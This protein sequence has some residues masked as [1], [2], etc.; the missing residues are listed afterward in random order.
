M[1]SFICL[2]ECWC[3][4]CAAQ[5]EDTKMM[6]KSCGCAPLTV[7]DAYRYIFSP[8]C[9]IAGIRQAALLRLLPIYWS[10]IHCCPSLVLSFSLLLLPL[11]YPFV[12][13]SFA[14]LFW[15]SLISNIQLLLTQLNLFSGRLCQL[16][17]LSSTSDTDTLY[18]ILISWSAPL[19]NRA[20]LCL[21]LFVFL[22]ISKYS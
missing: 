16:G 12:R 11:D 8:W 21:L 2:E 10:S 20:L 13:L 15:L 17:L 6:T 22:Y 7:P 9:M 18:R 1:S 3:N 19:Q 14:V 5:W 4:L